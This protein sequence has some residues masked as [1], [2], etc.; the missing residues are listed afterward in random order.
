MEE[1]THDQLL[2]IK[3]C[4][5]KDASL[6]RPTEQLLLLGNLSAAADFDLV[7]L[8]P[9]GIVHYEYC[10]YRDKNMTVLELF[11]GIPAS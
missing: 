3:D 7:E 6:G 1:G 9:F 10:E 11:D 2:Q 5:H 8:K 4:V